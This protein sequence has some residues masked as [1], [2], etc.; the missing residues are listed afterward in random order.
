MSNSTWKNEKTKS[1]ASW[2]INTPEIWQSAQE[3]ARNN[4]DAPIIYRAWI[5]NTGMQNDFT[6]DGISVIDPTLDFG[7]LSEVLH[8]FTLEWKGLKSDAQTNTLSNSTPTDFETEAKLT[9]KNSK[10][11]FSTFQKVYQGAIAFFILF[12]IVGLLGMNESPKPQDGKISELNADDLMEDPMGT[13]DN[14]GKR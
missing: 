2:I 3:F 13:F 5:K 6:P 10:K 4:P 8:T 1:V 14:Q 12:V 11:E 7:T 9:S